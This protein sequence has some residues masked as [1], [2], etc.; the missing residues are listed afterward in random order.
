MPSGLLSEPDP[1][2]SGGPLV[3]PEGVHLRSV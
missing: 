3:C 1:D 2:P